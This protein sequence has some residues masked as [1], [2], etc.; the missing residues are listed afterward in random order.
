[1]AK[2]TMEEYEERPTLPADSIVLLKVQEINVRER[3][4]NR[5]ETFQKLEFKFKLLDIQ[6]TG[7]G[8]PK[9]HYEALIGTQLYGSVPFRFNTGPENKLRLWTEAI[10]GMELTAGFE[11]DTELLENKNVRGIT[12]TYDK[13]TNDPRTGLPFKGMQVDALLP[14]GGGAS[15]PA[16][17]PKQLSPWDHA[18]PTQQPATVPAGAGWTDEPPF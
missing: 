10:L 1:M 2:I 4:G 17:A 13:R 7:D 6:T 15:A 16:A 8:S 9:E 18:Q 12:S 5:G 11:L 3:Q 14:V